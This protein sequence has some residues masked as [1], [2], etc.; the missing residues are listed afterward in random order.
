MIFDVATSNGQI[1]ADSETGL[2]VWCEIDPSATKGKWAWPEAHWPARIDVAEYRL[3]WPDDP[4][5]DGV[6]ILDVG[7][8]MRN[9]EYE[10]PVE[11]YR[12]DARE[13]RFMAAG[14]EFDSGINPGA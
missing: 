1:S 7:Y 2:V 6:D 10:P 11:E 13:F 5:E 8:W 3:A 9:G 4:I 14:S 12:A